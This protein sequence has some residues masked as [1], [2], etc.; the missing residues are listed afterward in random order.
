MNVLAPK[1]VVGNAL[2]LSTVPRQAAIP[3]VASEQT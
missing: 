2:P 3:E 1:V